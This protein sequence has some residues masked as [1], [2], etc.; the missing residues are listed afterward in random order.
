MKKEKILIKIGDFIAKFR[1]LFLSIFIFLFIFGLINI[2]NV[3]VNDDI[4]NYLPNDTETKKGLKI[5]ED[6]FGNYDNINLMINDIYKEEASELLKDF[7]RNKRK[8]K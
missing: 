4:V 8:Q 3:K 6:E 7:F 5:M 2:N 1:Y